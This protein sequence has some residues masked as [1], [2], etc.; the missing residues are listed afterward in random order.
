MKQKKPGT[1]NAAAERYGDSTSAAAPGK[2]SAVQKRYSQAPKPGSTVQKDEGDAP[3]N[4]QAPENQATEPEAAA[5]SADDLI[6]SR[7]PAYT[8]ED[9]LSWFRDQVREKVESWG[10]PSD[11]AAIRLASETV[12][13]ATTAVVALRWSDTWGTRP[14]TREVP[15]SMAP[16]DARAALTAIQALPG[17]GSMQGGDRSILQN[18]LGGESNQLSQTARDHLRGQ[19]AGLGSQTAEQQAAALTGIISSQDAIPALVDEQVATTPVE[20]EL[21]GPTEQ[22]GYAFRGVTADAE[23][24]QAVYTDSVQFEIVAPKAP[25]PNLHYHTVQQ[26]ADAASYLP[27][28]AR[29]V[30]TTVLLN[31]QVN[32]DDAYWAVEYNDPNFHSYMTAGAAGVVTIY[33]DSGN[34]PNDNYMRG[35]MIHETGHTWSY[36]TWGEDTTQGKWVDW[37]TAM[38]NDK[39]A[40]SGYANASIAEDVAETVTVYVSVQGTPQFEEYRSIVPH[41][42]AMLDQEYR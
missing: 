26:A 14:S 38:N 21:Q 2:Q 9:F 3:A 28:P 29:Q 33:P 15:L 37:Q 20:Y 39:V 41:R 40:V 7:D 6:L 35:T 1:G 25:D 36:Q 12:D 5:L 22:A 8:S 24:W 23:V 4:A 18:M 10:F 42:F 27:K 32:P 16:I 31:A 13:N 34:L 17:W 11:D 19:F 30:I